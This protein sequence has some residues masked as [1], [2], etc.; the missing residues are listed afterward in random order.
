MLVK[1]EILS[2]ELYHLL[3]LVE[4]QFN[5]ACGV[6]SAASTYRKNPKLAVF[7]GLT[8]LSGHMKVP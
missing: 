1:Q 7:L 6:I 2:G 8:I 3:P 5:R 4:G